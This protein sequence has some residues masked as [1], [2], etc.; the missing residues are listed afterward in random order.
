[1]KINYQY[2]KQAGFDDAQIQQALRP[3]LEAAGFDETSI[4]QYFQNQS[5]QR[6]LSL[7]GEEQNGGIKA[8]AAAA[9]EAAAQSRQQGVNLGFKD[10]IRLG[11]EQSV[12]GMLKRG[13]E[14][15]PLTQEEEE[16]LNFLERMAMG[17]SGF[18][19]DAPVY[20]VGGKMGAA[21][22]GAAGAAVG[23]VAPGVGTAAG[24]AVGAAVGGAS[25]AFGFQ[26][27]ARQALIDLYRRGEVASWDEL[28]Y[29]V[30][31][32]SKEFG[33][34]AVEGTVMAAAGAAGGV[35]AKAVLG[36]AAGRTGAGALA[37]K[38]TAKTLPTGSEVLGLTAA[39][40]AVEGRV[41][42]VQ[43]FA[44]NA[45]MIL[46]LKG[47]NKVSG[48]AFNRMRNKVVDT[49]YERFIERGEAPSE[50]IQ[51]I[52][53]DPVELQKVLAEKEQIKQGYK[54]VKENPLKGTREGK[55][56]VLV[57]M[58]P[59]DLRT[60]IIN[61]GAAIKDP[62]TGDIVVQGAELARATGTNGNFGF[63]KM[64]FKH[65]IEL[66]EAQ[67]IPEI[68]RT[69]NPV[70]VKNGNDTWRV[71]LDR[72]H[73][74][75]VAFAQKE[76]STYKEITVFKERKNAGGE[77]PLSTKKEDAILRQTLDSQAQDTD[78]RVYSPASG[79]ATSINSITQKGDGV[80]GPFQSLGG[81]DY[82]RQFTAG[83]Q[84]PVGEKAVLPQGQVRAQD[85]VKKSQ[86]IGELVRAAGVPV[87]QKGARFGRAA[88]LFYPKEE[89]IRVKK[90][91][92]LTTVAHEIGH[93]LEKSLFGKVG[94]K[95][96]S[97]YHGE[98]S[99]L[100]TKPRG[101]PSKNK[102]A[103]EGFAEFITSYVADPQKARESAPRFYA[104]F[105]KELAAKDPQMREA[106]QRAREETDK[107]ARQPA[108]MEVLSHIST[109][110]EAGARLTAAE[111]WQAVKNK[112]AE[113]I[114]DDKAPLR[115]VVQRLE[116]KTGVKI[117]WAKNP[118]IMARLFPG[119]AG[120]AEAFVQNGAFD[121]N[122]LQKTGKSLQ[123]ILRPVEN[124]DEL[125]AYLVS[126][127][128]VE[129][130]DRAAAERRL[131]ASEGREADQARIIETGV[132]EEAARAVVKELEGKYDP[133]A[134]EL[135]AF[136][137]ALLKY[138]LDGQL[139]SR[140]TYDRVRAENKAHVPFYRVL[141]NK[142]D[143]ALGSRSMGSKQVL[144]RM[145]GSTRDIVDPLEGILKDVYATVNAVERNRVGLAL[146]DLAQVEGAGEFVFKVPQDMKAVHTTTGETVFQP[147]AAIDKANQIKVFRKG[148]AEIYEVDPD[149]AKIVNGLNGSDAGMLVR[150]LGFFAK[151]LRAGATGL[152]AT[153]S[154]KNFLRDTMFAYLTSTSG[155][156]PLKSFP[157]NVK[158]ALGK[159]EAYWQFMKAGGGMSSFVSMD[160]K[161]MQE[162]L[163]ALE[164]TGYTKAVWN[165]V[166]GKR[167]AEAV[168]VGLLSP[169]RWVSETSELITRLGEFKSSM[170]GK[171]FTKEN[172]EK[173]GFNAR[174]VTL[175][176]AKGGV[177]SK[178]LNTMTAFFNASVQGFAKTGD[179]LSSRPRAVK[180]VAFL[181]TLGVLEAL[182]NYDWKKG[183][184][185]EDIAEVVQAQKNIN[186]VFKI[187]DVIFR[188]P[189]PQQ[190]GF[191]ATF[192]SQ[193][194]TAALDK[195][196]KNEREG[197]V[198]N[199]AQAFFNEFDL[200]PVPT[201]L[202]VPAELYFNRSLFFDRPIVPSAAE[203]VLPEYQYGDYTSELAKAVSAKLGGWI[204][205]E[206]T[207][208]P[209]KAEYMVRGWMGGVG[210]FILQATDAAL[211]KAGVLPDPVRP[212]DTLSDVPFVKAFVVRHPSG[213]AESIQKFY[214]AYNR[215]I[216]R[217]N[218]FKLEGKRQNFQSQQDLSVYAP[219]AGLNR[220]YTALGQQSAAIRNI[221][222]NPNL[223]ADEKRQLI[224]RLYLAKIQFAKQGLEVIKQMDETVES[225]QRA[226]KNRQ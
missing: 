70:M 60:Y 123:E 144:K 124:L 151:S 193:M 142:G 210:S 101:N 92:D 219:Y 182:Y 59:D 150:G 72:R 127:R 169:V 215:S 1:M 82:G 121:F 32:A 71:P 143:Y 49:L 61:R 196:N 172:L 104:F 212:A 52:M 63:S 46:G 163:R 164:R 126:K 122:T 199:L 73:N 103:A 109:G 65:G 168:D 208:S 113:Q 115:R 76:G 15:R 44:D 117:D 223:S 86:I 85:A 205:K 36:A 3:K 100:A 203:N 96:I 166:S 146:A 12:V 11:W 114:F 161:V 5:G 188:V 136:Q 224:D 42:T 200:N 175:D 213:S 222:N 56:D 55:D 202:A 131:A 149:V 98:L 64:I 84:I 75:I 21:A 7:A 106:L 185:D 137:D 23:S 128:A 167:F 148:K 57:T 154:I 102:V 62:K 80:K 155:F 183:K 184:E 180:A 204:G 189:K 74:L 16:S 105:E 19:S 118:Y 38:A 83:T 197:V 134:R 120:R 214:T 226:G 190:I 29:R 24:G 195:L 160:R 209:A 206:N 171:E 30:K 41:P 141:D 165:A 217:Y 22:G 89:M 192:F 107:W 97:E 198:Q 53:Q 37:L 181:G 95:E 67:R 69:Y 94:S 99:K 207:F 176:F 187:G 153:F 91:N 221:Y 79:S 147:S 51:K 116:E 194:T 201:G 34:G 81:G 28:I 14:P 25:G 133:V 132:R 88:G 31:N 8:L 173:A 78:R 179:I 174:E 138:Q 35:G 186:F 140:E 178:Y 90:A 6:P 216:K 135:Y 47:M 26:R 2:L 9:D 125:R 13:K 139:I 156:N 129:L 87:R 225:L 130:A 170:R 40:S 48:A 18:V 110:P 112:I 43:D 119:W 39:S 10:A 191:I 157:G 4:N 220:I 20:F 218:S 54:E 33:K 159:N 50:A 108:V 152:N 145:K 211:R 68:I 158:M 177:A 58:R 111:K 45:G 77:Y 17:L 93:Y 27:A 66:K 162:N